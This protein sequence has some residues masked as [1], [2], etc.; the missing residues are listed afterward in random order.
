MCCCC[1]SDPPSPNG[2]VVKAIV[3]GL[4]RENVNDVLMY[5]AF[6][7]AG[8]VFCEEPQRAAAESVSLAMHRGEP[9]HV[10][11]ALSLFAPVFQ[12]WRRSLC[13]VD[14]TTRRK[15]IYV[16]VPN[17]PMIVLGFKLP[18]HVELLLGMPSIDA[19]W[20]EFPQEELGEMVAGGPKRREF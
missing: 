1:C 7:G 5:A 16:D 17:A 12:F 3:D 9:L 6:V 8:G 4:R 2:C 19:P 18:A 13:L 15:K 14:T 11:A 10:D 20:E